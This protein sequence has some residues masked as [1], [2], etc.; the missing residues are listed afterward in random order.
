M[1]NN[2]VNTMNQETSNVSKE[3]MKELMFGVKLSCVLG[4]L[5]MVIL[6]LV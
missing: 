2:Y 5:G 3:E 4:T 6:F 1:Q